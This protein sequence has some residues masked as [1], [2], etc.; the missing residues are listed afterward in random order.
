VTQ[1][2]I[3]AGMELRRQLRS[4]VFW[5]VA[6]ISLLMVVGSSVI[7]AL[8][9]E[10]TSG[11]AG[12]AELIVRV[13]L[14]WT[15]FYL[16]TAAALVG[17]AT[18]RDQLSGFAPIVRATP[19]PRG[20]Y[21]LGRL[22]GASAAVLL[23]FLTVPLGLLAARL[24]PAAHPAWAAP[25]APAVHA[26]ALLAL[27]IPNL[28]LASALFAAL[29]TATR[30]MSGCLIGAVALLTLYGLGSADGSPPFF[31]P[32]GFA[33]AA[34]FLAG[35]AMPLVVNRVVWAVVALLLVGLAVWL[36]RRSPSGRK[37]GAARRLEEVA[38][39]P[40]APSR[41]PAA[42][43]YG[44]G[45]LLAQFALRTRHHV[46][47]TVRSPV[48]NILLV[49]GLASCAANLWSGVQTGASVPT[50]LAT[51]IRAFVLVPVVVVLFFAGEIHWSDR[52]HGID[53]IIGSLPTP[54]AVFLLAEI[55]ALATILLLLA[56][57]TGAAL[58]LL[59]LASGRPPEIASVLELYVLPKTYDWLLLGV[60]AFFLQ[61]LSPNKLAGW[62]YFVL[63]LI[64]NMALDQAGLDN[65]FLHYGRYPGAPL[66]PSLSGDPSAAGIRSLW[67][68]AALLLL[69]LA[70]AR[71]GRSR[72]ASR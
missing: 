17:E 44:R 40:S 29:A 6:V 71:A 65:P 34:S 4:P 54:R 45:A 46:R 3:L 8:R 67:A 27:A 66:P 56:V 13:H 61:T 23:C 24:L 53:G 55:T 25:A 49:L 38:Q 59:L 31:E 58:P 69:A 39:I 60:L 20:T 68:V 52:A 15:L 72:I 62:G 48:F 35:D 41:P 26:V 21:L 30:S 51:L 33:A 47:E 37:P 9:I 32:F 16:F 42:P 11:V 10:A 28:L 50:L 64:A 18:T 12:G 1:G 7:D 2:A 22:A 19:V 14:V 36:D 57:A 70:L 63:F 5:I 43:D